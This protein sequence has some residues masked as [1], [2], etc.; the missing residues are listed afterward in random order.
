MFRA[1]I[2]SFME[3]YRDQWIL[4][5]LYPKMNLDYCLCV[6]DQQIPNDKINYL[7]GN[8]VIAGEYESYVD[9][10]EIPPLDED[11]IE[12]VSFEDV[13]SFGMIIFRW[14]DR[15]ANQSFVEESNFFDYFYNLYFKHLRYW[16]WFLDT[17]KINL[18]VEFSV[19][20]IAFD[21]FVYSLC[22]LKN[23]KFLSLSWTPLTDR[24]IW[25]EDWEKSA[26]NTYMRYQELLQNKNGSTIQLSEVMQAHYDRQTHDPNPI[27][28]YTQTKEW[29]EYIEPRRKVFSHLDDAKFIKNLKLQLKLLN[30]RLFLKRMIIR[31]LLPLKPHGSRIKYGF[32]ETLQVK[33]KDM[34][35]WLRLI[36]LD[37]WLIRRFK[38]YL[39][40]QLRRSQEKLE[41]QREEIL[42][43][44]KRLE[45]F[46]FYENHA[47]EP[48]LSQKYIYVALHYQPE[49]T[50]MPVA[51][52]FANQLLIVQM[53]AYCVPDD[54][55]I[56]VKEH[57]NQDAFYRSIKFYQEMLAI[58]N[59]RLITRKYNT[60]ELTKN[61]L[62]VATA[63]GTVG[64]EALFKGKPVLMFGHYVYQYAPGVLQ[65]STIEDCQSAIRKIID[66]NFK[67]DPDKLKLFLQALEETSF[68]LPPKD[69]EQQMENLTNSLVSYLAQSSLGNI[70]VNNH[71]L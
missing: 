20:H 57:P 67:P 71:D 47:I 14:N 70:Y 36:T 30:I 60:F 9:W 10:H 50:T 7:D 28:M 56:Y 37:V 5:D 65:I 64:W 54:V 68:Y 8:K 69:I 61:A 41:S 58:P 16:N 35:L 46:G 29:Q 59:V 15:S 66:E 3:P 21:N 24:F 38:N 19:P 45:L 42:L 40:L 34:D 49:A 32:W 17:H 12:S 62:A 4:N 26:V 27:P 31:L 44:L 51:G 39:I 55:L 18:V 33:L 23:I 13:L 52:I 6:G 53:L 63:T 43:N 11:V 48:D 25:I 2:I 22:K 1:I